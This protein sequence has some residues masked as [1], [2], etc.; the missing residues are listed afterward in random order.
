MR[1]SLSAARVAATNELTIIPEINIEGARYLSYICFGYLQ[2]IMSFYYAN[3][4]TIFTDSISAEYKKDQFIADVT[5]NL[6][7]GTADSLSFI[8]NLPPL[9]LMSMQIIISPRSLWQRISSHAFGTIFGYCYGATN[10]MHHGFLGFRLS[11]SL[12][13]GQMPI[14]IFAEGNNLLD[15]KYYYLAGLPG[16]SIDSFHRNQQENHVKYAAIECS[17]IHIAS[18]ENI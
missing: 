13:A 14:E 5:L 8:P 11:Y 6:R 18:M 7:T 2:V 4:A 12:T 9:D 16:V 10:S 17:I 3:K 1:T 15:Q